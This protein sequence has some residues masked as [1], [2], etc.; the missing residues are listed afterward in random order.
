MDISS[1][2]NVFLLKFHTRLAKKQ[3]PVKE[4]ESEEESSSEDEALPVLT[5]VKTA[6]RIVKLLHQLPPRNCRI[7][8]NRKQNQ[9]MTRNHQKRRLKRKKRRWYS[10]P[11]KMLME[12]KYRE[13]PHLKQ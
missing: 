9:R 8:Q 10:Y 12:L 7:C 4:P 6:K 1:V 13:D 11:Q 3:K 5:P 2:E